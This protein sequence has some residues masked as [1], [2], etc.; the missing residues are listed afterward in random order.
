MPPKA[1]QDIHPAI[2]WF[3]NHFIK[4][5]YDT[6]LLNSTKQYPYPWLTST[7][8]LRS[9]DLSHPLESVIPP[10]S[11]LSSHSP[12]GAFLPLCDPFTSSYV[13]TSTNPT[14]RNLSLIPSTP[15]PPSSLPPSIDTHCTLGS[16]SGRAGAKRLRGLTAPILPTGYPQIHCT[17]SLY[18]TAFL[19]KLSAHPSPPPFGRYLSRRERQDLCA[20]FKHPPQTEL[21][22]AARFPILFVGATCGRPQNV[23]ISSE[24]S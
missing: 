10:P 2:K 21:Y 3:P 20:N 12:K 7:F 6:L 14:N 23:S 18:E 4:I 16:P 17:D 22:G 9:H 19:H 5:Q 8:L 11:G 15:T 13:K 1:K 24:N